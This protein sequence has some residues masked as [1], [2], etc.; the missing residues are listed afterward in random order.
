MRA[1]VNAIQAESAIQVTRLLRLEESQLASAPRAGAADAVVGRAG[2][3]DVRIA[4]LNF[5]RRNERLRKVELA[6]GANVFAEACAPK[7]SVDDK[8]RGE[9]TDDNPRRPP[10]A[11]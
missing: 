10:R 3:A 8:R 4:N 1:G 11:V 7:Q 9:I 5:E 6:D 2:S